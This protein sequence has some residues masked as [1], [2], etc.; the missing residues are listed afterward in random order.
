MGRTKAGGAKRGEVIKQEKSCP[1]CGTKMV[2]VKRIPGS[3]M[4][5]A[6]QNFKY[7]EVAIKCIVKCDYRENMK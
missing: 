3:K 1:L 6:C 5:W 2:P 4:F 7:S